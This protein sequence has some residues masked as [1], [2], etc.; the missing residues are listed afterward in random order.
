MILYLKIIFSTLYLK[1][2]RYYGTTTNIGE[3]ENKGVHE[4]DPPG[5][6]N[7]GNDWVLV[8]ETQKRY[9]GYSKSPNR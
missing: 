9:L 2:I 6:P 4:F 8:L 1:S 5:E 3:L 7:P